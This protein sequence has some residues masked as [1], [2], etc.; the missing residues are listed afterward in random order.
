MGFDNHFVDDLRSSCSIVDLVGRYVPIKKKGKDYGA[1]CP[2]HNEKTPSFW[3]SE[4]KQIFKCFGCGAGGDIFGFVMQIENLN[5]PEAIR[6]IA[7]LNGVPLPAQTKAGSEQREKRTRLLR[8]MEEAVSF[9]RSSLNDGPG[10]IAYLKN[11]GIGQKTIDEFGVGFAPPGNRLMK[12]LVDRG[13]SR[14]EALEGGLLGRN[15]RGEYY[16]YF[17]NRV[18]VPI[19]DLNGR[20]IAFGGRILGD[21]NPKYLNSRETSL[22]IKSRHLFGLD[23]ARD[24][25]RRQESAVLVEGYFDMIVPYLHGVQNIV[26]SLGTSLTQDQASLLGRYSKTVV[27]NYDPDLAGTKAAARSI[28]L[29]LAL[30]FQIRVLVLPQGDDPDTYIRREGVEAY[31]AQIAKAEDFVEFLLSRSMNS[32]EDPYSPRAKS[33]VV[34][35]VTPY[36][37]KVSDRIERAE[38]I[39][40]LATRLRIEEK[41]L[42]SEIRKSARKPVDSTASRIEMRQRFVTDSE[43]TLLAAILDPE[44]RSIA[45]EGLEEDLFAE[46]ET[47]MVFL[48]VLRKWRAGGTPTAITIRD[49]L[50]EAGEVLDLLERLAFSVHNLPI[51][52]ET[53]QGSKNALKRRQLRRQLSEAKALLN[54]ASDF[55][56]RLE[57]VSRIQELATR[58]RDVGEGKSNMTEGASQ[59]APTQK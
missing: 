17:R 48:S 37:L 35:E 50:P 9:F 2:F 1:L 24:Q 10:P 19:R 34:A 30:G 43:R 59:T 46:T 11:R 15:D 18:M 25:I 54:Q 20:T 51:T 31:K 29:L 42:L 22:Y 58:L 47:E 40:R 44:W 23:L 14:E 39:T 52:E 3:V 36:L 13:Y 16:S 28:D 41:L 12:V 38:Y 8:M 7:E 49:E 57:Q 32:H 5:F 21:G 55:R 26:A 4:S 6:F 53:V 33:A 45:L 56:T 27:I